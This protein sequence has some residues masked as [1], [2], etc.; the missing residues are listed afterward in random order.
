MCELQPNLI[1]WLDGE[2]P[3]GEAAA[4]ASHVEGCE[5]CRGQLA[6]FR[7]AS[8]SF[9]LYCHSVMAVHATPRVSRW[10]PALAAM[11]LVAAS[12]LFFSFPRKQAK[13][14]V[15]VPAPVVAV[16]PAAPPLPE[17]APPFAPRK[18]LHRRHPNPAPARSVASWQP[19]ETAVEIAIP[20]D[21]VFAPGAVPA[22]MNFLAEI[23]IAPDGSVRQVRLRQ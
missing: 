7:K 23:S 3:S 10:T 17:P 12:V 1:A 22:G 19:T 15:P 8:E 9:Q 21:A 4:V 6:A 18:T 20:A 11:V 14:P 13:A 2:L 16:N 5:D